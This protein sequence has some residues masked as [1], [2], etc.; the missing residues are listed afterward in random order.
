M[1]RAID[2]TGSAIPAYA[3]D[4]TPNPLAE[5]D[6][7][8]AQDY[9]DEECGQPSKGEETDEREGGLANFRAASMVRPIEEGKEE[10]A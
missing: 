5:T 1:P 10:F 7:D 4:E 2:D 9:R 8:R 3:G 6:T